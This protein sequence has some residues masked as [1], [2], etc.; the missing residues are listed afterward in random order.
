MKSGQASQT[1]VLVCQGRAWA[2]AAHACPGFSDPTALGLLPMEAAREVRAALEGKP[3][4]GIKRNITRAHLKRNGLVQAA[5]TVA[6]DDAVKGTSSRQLV[7]LG[8]GLDGRAWRM[9][10]LSEVS[11]FEVDHPDTQR[12]KREAVGELEQR[13]REVHFVAVDFTRD[14]LNER[15]EAAG[16]DSAAPTTWIWEGV[17]MYL[18]PNQVEATLSVIHDRSAPGSRLIIVYHR[19][20]WVL[21]LVNLFVARLGEPFRSTYT[22]S[23]MSVLLAQHGF[24]VTEDRSAAEVGEGLS[25]EVGR[26]TRFATHLGIVVADR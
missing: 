8:A 19:P 6:V 25:A 9:P 1:A 4:R 15:L 10:E 20:A 26:A 21:K 5:R 22:P 16:H 17:V 24:R 2:H 11:V 7:I 14:D 3:V 12:A 18:T 23:A 13:A